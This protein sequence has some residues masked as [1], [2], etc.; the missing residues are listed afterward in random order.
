MDILRFTLYPEVI[1]CLFLKSSAANRAFTYWLDKDAY[2]L[3]QCYE[4]VLKGKKHNSP[5][6]ITACSKTM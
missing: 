2:R 4:I 6:I 5:Y 3:M 1:K